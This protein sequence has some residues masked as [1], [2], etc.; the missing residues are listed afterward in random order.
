MQANVSLSENAVTG[1]LWFVMMPKPDKRPMCRVK[2][3]K[4][5]PCKNRSSQDY[6]LQDGR[7]IPVC[8]LHPRLGNLAS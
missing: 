4:G 3:L 8:G 1:E 6:Q 7:T 5:T 2:T